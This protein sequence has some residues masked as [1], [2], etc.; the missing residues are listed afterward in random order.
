ML[1][2]V[3]KIQLSP[4]APKLKLVQ[5]TEK[6]LTLDTKSSAE[7]AEASKILGITVEEALCQSSSLL[8]LCAEAEKQGGTILWESSDGTQR[9]LRLGS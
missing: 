7:L 3:R 6:S 4:V 2:G 8:L 5:R 9:E 1:L